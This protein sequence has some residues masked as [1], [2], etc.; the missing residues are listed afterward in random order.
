M[1]EPT[2][3]PEE[4]VK[5]LRN[6]WDTQLKTIETVEGQADKLMQMFFEQSDAVRSE[7]KQLFKQWTEMVKQ[8]QTQYKKMMEENLSKMESMIKKE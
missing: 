7:G 3:I 5:F 8:S 1:I 2:K 6:C 4:M